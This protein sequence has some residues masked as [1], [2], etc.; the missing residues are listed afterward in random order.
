M[1][2][3]E[4]E[5][6]GNVKK[7]AIENVNAVERSEGPLKPP[8][9]RAASKP[10]SSVIPAKKDKQG[11]APGKPDTD[12]AFLKAIAST[13][14]GKKAEDKFDREFNNLKISKPEPEQQQEPEEE[15]GVLADFGDD[16]DLRGNFMVVVEM[17]VYKKD[18]GPDS[19]NSAINHVC[20]GKPNFKKFKKVRRS[21]L[22]YSKIFIECFTES[23]RFATDHSRV[24]PQQ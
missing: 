14:R 1:D 20:S 24:V 3:I 17:D 8:S 5:T 4:R 18:K 19:Q 7:R 16:T 22:I 11:A 15:W 2:V 9:T 12:A 10:P 21:F 23:W 13:R 6:S